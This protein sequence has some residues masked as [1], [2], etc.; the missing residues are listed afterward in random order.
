MRA[1]NAKR[2]RESIYDASDVHLYTIYHFQFAIWCI[3]WMAYGIWKKSS[4]FK[5]LL[6]YSHIH[7]ST[8]PYHL[9]FRQPD[10]KWKKYEL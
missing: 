3:I 6:I 7:L 1:Q 8:E 2:H 5:H 10:R 4:K 9:S